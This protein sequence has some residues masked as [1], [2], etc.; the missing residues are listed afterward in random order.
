MFKIKKHVN[1]KSEGYAV[2][3]RELIDT[4]ILS[5]KFHAPNY[6]PQLMFTQKYAVGTADLN[7]GEKITSRKTADQI[8]SL[9]FSNYS[10]KF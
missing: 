5:H 10:G 6:S 4:N 2:G 3:T 9:D 8:N 7:K 1:K